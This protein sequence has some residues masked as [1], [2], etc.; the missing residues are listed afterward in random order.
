[1]KRRE[2]ITLIG[3]AAA[4]PLAARAQQTAK[5][6]VVGFLGANTPA[7]QK[8]STEAFVQRLRELGWTEGRNL[9]IEYRWAEGRFERSAGLLADLVRMHVNIIFTHATQN[10]VAAKQATSVIPIVFAAAGDPVGNHLVASL[11]HPGGNVTGLSLQSNDLAGKRLG[12][13]RE[14]DP[15]LRRL[16]FLANAANPNTMV[17]AGELQAAA[18]TF[19]IDVVTSQ[20]RR[21]DDIA[22]PA[23]ALKGHVEA[24]YVQTDPLMNTNRA[25]ITDLA[26]KARLPSMAGFREYAETNGLTSYG[27][28]FSDLFRRGADYV[29][30]IL[31]GAKPSDLPVE[32]PTKFDFIINLKT[33]KELGLTVPPTLL[34][35]ADEVIE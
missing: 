5:L 31:R 15:G 20:I 27:P 9:I 30:K 2:F 23:E 28:N 12:I 25:R 10:V 19:G 18:R 14:L 26:L 34:A 24:L 32:Q 21:A 3:G 16:V 1:M 7:T 8:P 13:L 33:A 6:P 4:A 17:E 22:L 35:R 29:D 11:A